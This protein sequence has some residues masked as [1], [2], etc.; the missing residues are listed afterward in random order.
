M[1]LSAPHSCSYG[2]FMTTSPEH[3]H[4]TVVGTDGSA[5]SQKAIIW[6]I[7]HAH[8]GDSITLIHAWHPYVYGAE[9]MIA[10]DVDD[11]AARLCWIRPLTLLNHKQGHVESL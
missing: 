2:D 5:N 7:E 4:H 8:T 6:A 10:Y 9:M 3:S 1:Y 11:S